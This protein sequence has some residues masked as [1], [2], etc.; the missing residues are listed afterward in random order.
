[1][2]SFYNLCCCVLL[3]GAIEVSIVSP[4]DGSSYI[5]GAPIRVSLAVSGD[6]ATIRPGW[7]ACCG[8]RWLRK[9]AS[10][11]SSDLLLELRDSTTTNSLPLRAWLENEDGESVSVSKEVTLRVPDEF[12]SLP[13]RHAVFLNDVRDWHKSRSRDLKGTLACS[14]LTGQEQSCQC[15]AV[16][17]NSRTMVCNSPKAMSKVIKVVLRKLANATDYRDMK[18]TFSCPT[19]DLV[20]LTDVAHSAAGVI[21]RAFTKFVFVRDP[22]TR[23]VS[24]YRDFENRPVPLD[25]TRS[26]QRWLSFPDFVRSVSRIDDDAANE[27]VASQAHLCGLDTVHYDVVAVGDPNDST[28]TKP[29][30]ARL[31]RAFGRPDEYCTV[32]LEETDFCDLVNNTTSLHCSGRGTSS[33]NLDLLHSDSR[34]YDLVRSR[35]RRDFEYL[36]KIIGRNY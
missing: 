36:S 4:V 20:Q 15:P 14:E 26:D 18:R 7:L 6:A 8:S 21:L 10:V 19:P 2:F 31:C 3:A 28:V 22:F 5:P 1:M 16:D 13:S 9:C 25:K 17:A 11:S 32:E 33:A 23:L 24:F 35:Y 12:S 27:H 29:F 30:L 34:L